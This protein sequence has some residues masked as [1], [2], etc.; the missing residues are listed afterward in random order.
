MVEP[1][2]GYYGIEGNH[3]VERKRRGGVMLRQRALLECTSSASNEPNR[4]NFGTR[5]TLATSTRPHRVVV[6][7]L[8]VP[9]K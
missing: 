2:D 4:A 7:L 6:G 3:P 1:D 8:G 9:T 5:A